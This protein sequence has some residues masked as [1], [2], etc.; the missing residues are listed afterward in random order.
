M[1]IPC[2]LFEVQSL[3]RKEH[4]VAILRDN[5]KLF[6]KHLRTSGQWGWVMTIYLQSCDQ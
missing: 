2:V 5:R 6:K 1:T 3:P 4:Q